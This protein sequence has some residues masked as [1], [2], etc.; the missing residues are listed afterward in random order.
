M[1]DFQ[2]IL[3]VGNPEQGEIHTLL[4][5]FGQDGMVTPLHCEQLGPN[6]EHVT[7]ILNGAW[8]DLICLFADDLLKKGEDVLAFCEQLRSQD[9]KYRP[10]LVVQSAGAEEKRIAYLIQGADDILGPDISPEEFRVRLLVH[11]RRNLDVTANEI[12]MLPGLQFTGKVAQRRL[13]QHKPLALMIVELDQLDVYSEVYGDLPTHQVL[14]TFAAVL[15]RLVLLP[16]FI[17]QTDENHFVIVTHPDRADKLAALLCRQFETVSPNFYSDKDRK[18]GYMTSVITDNISQRVPLLSVSVGIA[19]TETQPFERFT[20]LFNT[21]QQ[22]KNLAR[23][24]PGCSWQGDRFRLAGGSQTE[25]TEQKL[26]ILVLETDAALAYLLK[27]TLAMEGYDVE[28]VNS[29]EDA[30]Q[31]LMEK[32]ASHL[33]SMVILDALINDEESGL[34][35]AS[36][37]HQQYPDM[38]I[39]CTSSL[40]QRQRVLQAGAD[41]YLPKPFELSSL[42]SWI[43]RLLREGR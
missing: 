9:L 13:N 29:L 8:P 25:T 7:P 5:N 22:M 17:S 20:S 18:Q 27:T 16:D 28:V 39:I 36:E 41:L 1:S 26:G 42:F 35:L 4:E 19:S 30:R 12:T 10:V 24:K 2:V 6:G 3:F 38:R 21:A 33:L 11:L 34:Q 43:H 40:H 31:S 32:A 23:M 15:S 37:I 14:K